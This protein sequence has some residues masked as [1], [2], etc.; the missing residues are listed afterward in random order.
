MKDETYL[1]T[2]EQGDSAQYYRIVSELS[3]EVFA[4]A[5]TVFGPEMICFIKYLKA[6]KVA[7][8]YSNEECTIELLALG[9]LW[10]SYLADAVKLNQFS[11]WIL[12][13]IAAMRQSFSYFK[14]YIDSIKGVLITLF[15]PMNSPKQLLARDFSQDRL[16]KLFNWLIAT[17]EYPYY[18]ERLS[19]WQS[20][21]KT[22]ARDDVNRLFNNILDF[23]DW[24][25]HRSRIILGQY[26][27][28]LTVFLNEKLVQH[29]WKEDIVF[30][31]RRRV[32]YHLNMVGAELMNQGFRERF[33]DTDR[34]VIL[35]P[36]CMREKK[37]ECRATETK[38]GI[39]CMNCSSTCRVCQ[40]SRL[41]KKYNFAVY[42]I[43][44]ESS[45]FPRSRY[46]NDL[47]IIGVA[48]VPNLLSGGWKAT[49]LGMEAQC[50]VLNY[51]GCKKHW[52]DSGIVTEIDMARLK[53]LLALQEKEQLEI[54]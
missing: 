21:F 23:A 54:I 40:L 12:A 5:K 18:Q 38:D 14:K 22:M 42:I 51:C 37:E 49:S 35:L 29:R 3:K 10:N 4:R 2:N 47:G 11:F 53:Q 39:I 34:K 50:V 27:A 17:G 41:G 52:H 28:N 46:K 8:E 30:C 19:H 20:F 1:L 6:N 32:E 36:I 31:S 13:K 7:Q 33:L 9:V 15:L 26:T 25:E 16:K 45:D 48:C 44:H 24:F 43:P